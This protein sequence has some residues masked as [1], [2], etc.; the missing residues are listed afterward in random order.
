[1]KE[2]YSRKRHLEEVKELEKYNGFSGR[3]S[4]KIR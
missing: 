1:V 3:R 4:E 2:I